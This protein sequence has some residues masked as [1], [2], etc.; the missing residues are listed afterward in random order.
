VDA[1]VAAGVRRV[2]I[3]LLDPNPRVNGGGLAQLCQAGIEVD[4]GDG[5][6][7]A[8]DLIAGFASYV[9][10]GRPLVTA[11]FAMSLDGRIATR[12]GHARWITGPAA[13]EHVHQV[14]ATT[15][16][17]LV[18][19]GTVLADDPQLT[20]RPSTLSWPPHQPLR[21]VLDTTGRL[22]RGA[23]VLDRKLPSQTIVA[24]TSAMAGPQRQALTDQGVRVVVFPSSEHGVDVTALIR[25]LG[26]EGITSLLVEGGARVHASFMEAGL[27]DRL[28]AYVAPVIIGG[29][30]AP[31]PIAGLGAATMDAA[32]RLTD[33][34]VV[35]LGDDLLVTATMPPSDG[36]HGVAPVS[37][38]QATPHLL[39]LS[40]PPEA[41]H[42]RCL[43]ESR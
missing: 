34:R 6:L 39:A 25:W 42:R 35:Q 17:I 5:Q 15:D 38:H 3:A 8:A 13:R 18:G 12:T 1:I 16:A 29:A 33:V 30:S 22:P 4:L 9:Q 10:R 14:R 21:L 23:R 31:G 41:D 37:A 27:V 28:M 32:T 20:A 26:D 43:V 7:A 2:A 11:K 19:S 24:T 36:S 40:Q